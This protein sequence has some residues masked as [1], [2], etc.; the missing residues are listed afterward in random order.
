MTTKFA[1][2]L[3]KKKRASTL[4]ALSLSEL[5]AVET[6]VEEELY[7]EAIVHLPC[8][9]GPSQASDLT[10]EAIQIP[11]SL[12]LSAPFPPTKSRF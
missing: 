5:N 1:Y 4:L 9:V 12:I 11:A 7:R 10:S 2:D 6:L 8:G 3:P